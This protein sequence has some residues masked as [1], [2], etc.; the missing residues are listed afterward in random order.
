MRQSGPGSVVERRAPYPTKWAS[1]NWKN[2]NQ[3]WWA[4]TP[5]CCSPHRFPSCV[6]CCPLCP[7]SQC[8]KKKFLIF[9]DWNSGNTSTYTTAKATQKVPVKKITIHPDY[10]LGEFGHNVAIIDLKKNVVTTDFVQPI[11]LPSTADHKTSTDLTVAGYEDL[12]CRDKLAPWKQG[13]S[14]FHLSPI[15]AKSVALSLSIFRGNSSA[16]TPIGCPFT[17]LLWLKLWGTPRNLWG[18]E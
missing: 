1:M 7:W 3:W 17:D 15:P 6:N 16:A 13:E 10:K 2:W 18:Y 8:G 11:C 14:S 12:S 4:Q 5:M 9:G